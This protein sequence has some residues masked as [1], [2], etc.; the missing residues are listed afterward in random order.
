MP[1]WQPQVLDCQQSGG[2]ALAHCRQHF[3]ADSNGVLFPREWLKK[4]DLP[5]VAEHGLGYFK[6]DAVYLL[7]LEQPQDMPGSFWQSLRQFM[8]QGDDDDTFRLLSYAAQ[9]STWAADHRFC[10]SCGAAMQ[11]VPGERAIR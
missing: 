6:G 11:Q 4:Q 1:V 7:E 8:L 5:V 3:L 9:T 2:W 10:G